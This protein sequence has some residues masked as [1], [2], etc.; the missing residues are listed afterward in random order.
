RLST[1][2]NERGVKHISMYNDF[3]VEKEVLYYPTDTHWN[4]TGTKLGAAKLIKY[5]RENN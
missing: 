4:D 2:L 1:A 5:L 3:S